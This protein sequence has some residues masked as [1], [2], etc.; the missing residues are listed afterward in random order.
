M[1]KLAGVARRGSRA[2]LVVLLGTLAAAAVADARAEPPPR[3]DQGGP[4]PHGIRRTFEAGGLTM[5]FELARAGDERT[6]RPLG[7]GDD[8][9]VRFEIR[10]ART[11]EPIR[12]LHPFAWIDRR[13]T[14]TPPSAA[15]VQDRIASYVGGLLAR[16]ADLDLNAYRVFVLNH[17]AT[18]SVINPLVSFSRTKLESLIRLPGRGDDLLLVRGRWLFVTLPEVSLVS[19]IDTE[20]RE[21]VASL[22]TGFG[23]RPRRL[24]ADPAGSTVWVA[25]DDAEEV[26]VISVRDLEVIDRVPV[27]KGLHAIAWFAPRD[28]V[29]VTNSAGGTLSV[30]DGASRRPRGVVAV[31][32]TPA[33]VAVSDAAELAFVASAN[34]DGIAVVDPSRLVR[35]GAIPAGPGLVRV[36]F[37]PGG[38]FGF[39][40]NQLES[41]A[42]V[43]DAA[44]REAL[45]VL[46]TVEGPDQI[47]FTDAYAYVRGVGST[48]ISMID[49]SRLGRA[50]VPAAAIAVAKAPA[51][52]LPDEIAVG[53]MIA[54]TP[55]RRSVMIA[56]TP[57][58]TLAYY[59]EGMLAPMGT[60][61]NYGRRPRGIAVVDRSLLEVEP[62]VY[63]SIATL[64]T[65][66]VQDVFFV[67][68]QPRVV[69]HLEFELAA[70]ASD[71][72]ERAVAIEMTEPQGMLEAG[73][74]HTLRFR[75][76][77]PRTGE[78]VV[79]LADLRL[80]T[81][82]RD[83][84][85]HDRWATTEA[86]DG[87]YEA[88]VVFPS[89]GRWVVVARSD[90]RGLDYDDSPVFEVGVV[91]AREEEPLDAGADRD[92]LER[93][94]EVYARGKTADGPAIVA[95][96][97]TGGPALPGTSFACANCHGE[98]GEG[99]SEG[100]LEPPSILWRELRRE[101]VSLLTKKARP[102]YEVAS[103]E[104]CIREGIDPAGEALHPGMPRYELD[105]RQLDA[106]VAYLRTLGDGDA[107]DRGVHADTLR[108]GTVLPLDG[109]RVSAGRAVE[110][111]LR[112]R[113]ARINERGGI[114]GRDLELAVRPARE[115]ASLA[116][117]LRALAEEDRVA[118]VVAA[119]PFAWTNEVRSVLA[120]TRTPLL[121]PLAAPAVDPGA[122]DP[123]VF[124]TFASLAD[125]CR[126][127][128]DEAARESGGAATLAVVHD[129]G[130][131]A[132]ALVAAVREQAE[133]HGMPGPT[134]LRAGGGLREQLVAASPTDLLLV[135]GREAARQLVPILSAEL[136]ACR[137]AGP[138]DSLVPVL[139]G[140]PRSLAS[141]T[142]VALG[143]PGSLTAPGLAAAAGGAI[144]LLVEG[145]KR[146]G[147]RLTRRRLVESL[148]S[149]RDFRTEGLGALTFAPGRRAGALAVAV[150]TVDP[151][152]GGLRVRASAVCPVGD[153]FPAGGS[154]VHSSLEDSGGR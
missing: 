140:M 151:A 48:D 17:D 149:V 14:R 54:P 64:V 9:R 84:T 113:V 7:P 15:Q 134:V 105:D 90:S 108:I 121:G 70:A 74:P 16:Q 76:V 42:V 136:P 27:G 21:L 51:S 45:A 8:V 25:L 73:R 32:R 10:D 40:L 153:G 94:R 52:S 3:P 106:L 66:G 139:A 2:A 34:G 126:V 1:R 31:G 46:D 5:R 80:M 91:A 56:S 122:G 20:T 69:E 88:R 131:T 128:V 78:P 141:R 145:A 112:E 101:R 92:R 103:L 37:E 62:G 143:A 53:P 132:N 63:E 11:G 85:R 125:Q 47:A 96:L 130:P 146:A 79:G 142:R 65:G 81:L 150:A 59:A 67:N 86:G 22:P 129:G 116:I 30:I 18:V 41:E 13:R 50:P 111:A 97:G 104:R 100:G 26:C 118:A 95:R 109:P 127:L 33:G 71:H 93:G 133:R 119:F 144:D 43:F 6:D 147:R 77:E 102:P 38:R 23:T 75:V 124:F 44:T 35:L 115:D 110:A 89:T 19:V 39:A 154:P 98:F 83:A 82:L 137:L 36:A 12:G 24:V 152:A 61:Q 120:R 4:S 68:D 107:P 29:C 138:A 72:E 123:L 99:T 49:L 28:L 117:A 114:Y 60:F 148:E 135:G 87:F 58:R 55:E 57:D